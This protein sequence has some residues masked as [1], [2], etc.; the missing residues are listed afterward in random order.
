MTRFIIIVGFVSCL[1]LAACGS[2]TDDASTGASTTVAPADTATAPSSV[3][4]MSVP[5]TSEV[6]AS[7]APATAPSS[8][9]PSGFVEANQ[10]V[11]AEIL[12]VAGTADDGPFYMVNL[13]DFHDGPADYPEDSEWFG[14][15]GAEANERY[16]DVI[17]PALASVGAAPVFVGE[18]ERTLLGDGVEWD[19]VAV[20]RY[21]SRAALLE[22]NSAPEVM[23]GLEHKDA[24]L[25]NTFAMLS[26]RMPLATP[27]PVD[28]AALPAPPTAD[29]P[30]FMMVHVIN[31]RDQA[32]Y[33]P[34]QEP[35]DAPISGI[36]AVDRYSTNA[37]DAAV[38]LGIR[39]EAWFEVSGTLLGEHQ[40][41]EQVRLNSFP[42]QAAF[43][44]LTTNA[45]WA[46]GQYHRTA[47]I[48][49]TYALMTQP[50]FF[51]PTFGDPDDQQPG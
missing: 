20:V 16:S 32:Q 30:G 27:P 13:L 4:P 2:S 29:D 25:A 42:S 36:E 48:E 45:D 21:P 8:G 15:T 19:Q 49:A 47:G 39:P 1:S 41:W 14:S 3:P 37:G 7:T 9:E 33:E 12:R 11:G 10:E 35:D 28:P 6:P 50:V 34:G 38:P 43:E 17:V 51:D 31:F 40:D 26:D 22:M 46:S 24:S 23:A 44:A 5:P 18:V